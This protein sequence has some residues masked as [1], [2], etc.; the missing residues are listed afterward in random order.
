MKKVKR[1]R[2]KETPETGVFVNEKS[3]FSQRYNKYY[4]VL[5][6]FNKMTFKIIDVLTGTSIYKFD[7]KLVSKQNLVRKVRN[8]LKILGVD[9]GFEVR[10]I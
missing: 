1:L 5:I 3:I 10:N 4:D 2:Y 8:K 6:D 9:F 7:G